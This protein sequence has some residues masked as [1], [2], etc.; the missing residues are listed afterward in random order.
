M[1]KIMDMI[2]ANSQCASIYFQM[3]DMNNIVSPESEQLG[4]KAFKQRRRMNE[5]SQKDSDDFKKLMAKASYTL[6]PQ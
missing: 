6:K 3:F 5:R 4:S 1:S 2:Y